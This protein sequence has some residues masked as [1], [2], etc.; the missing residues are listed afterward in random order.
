MT[1]S[2]ILSILRQRGDSVS[3]QEL[4]QLFGV[5]RTAVWKRIRQLQEE[6]YEIEAVPNRGYRLLS[7]P[8]VMTAQEVEGH[9]HTRWAGHPTYYFPTIGSTNQYAKQIAEEGAP[10]GA[11]V[12]AD[13]QTAGRGRRG[14]T[15]ATPPGTAIAM[16]LVL[17]PTLPL[18][19][20]AMV[21][22]VIG[23]A[24]ADACRE[25]CSDQVSIKWPN[26]VVIG[27]KKISGIL[28]EMSAEMN[29]VHYVVIG[30]GINVNVE[31]FPEELREIGTSLRI[32]TGREHNRAQLI[33]KIMEYFEK[34]YAC[35][36]ETKDLSG[37]R[38]H[39]NELLVNRGREVRVL[40]P[41]GEFTGVAEGINDLGELLVRRE[42]G[43]LVNVYAGEVSVRGLYGYV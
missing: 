3:G 10:E 38:E 29:A 18:D 8:D 16:T 28:T 12:I 39:Y 15:W 19:R 9:L 1:A 31:E 7:A 2:D 20:I 4:C 41:N 43:E 24:A 13:E 21:T 11:L 23:L 25:L 37:L 27:G 6:G 36:Q 17:R 42:D 5:S 34:Y 26:D 32:E 14:H 22:P 40:D 33:A 30:I 35:L